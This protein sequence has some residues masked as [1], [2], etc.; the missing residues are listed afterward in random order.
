MTYHT[1]FLCHLYIQSLPNTKRIADALGS[2]SVLR[3][4]V[5][6]QPQS[7]TFVYRVPTPLGVKGL[8]AGLT[9][10]YQYFIIGI[11]T[12]YNKH[13]STR[14]YVDIK[15]YIGQDDT[16]L[17]VLLAN[18]HTIST[19]VKSALKTKSWTVFSPQAKETQ[20]LQK[21]TV[22]M[23][24]LPTYAKWKIHKYNICSNFWF[25]NFFLKMFIV[26]STFATA[27]TSNDVSI[28]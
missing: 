4:F 26:L 5:D 19:E 15:S 6:V 16:I 24:P 22:A 7:Q 25:L 9:G 27:A 18:M 1:Q 21:L 11:N 17:C 20:G 12:F 8:A 14:C 28:L 10:T 3:L 2:P 13:S 23:T